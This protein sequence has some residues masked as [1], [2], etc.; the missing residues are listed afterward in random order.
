MKYD[1]RSTKKG[2]YSSEQFW[3]FDKPFLTNKGCMSNDFISIGNEDAFVDKE[4]E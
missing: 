3:N 2:T 1:K 4:G